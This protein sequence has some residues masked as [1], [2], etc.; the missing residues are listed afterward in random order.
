MYGPV[1]S[2]Y[3]FWWIFP[4]LMIILCFILMRSR[5]GSM[6]CGF[7]PRNFDNN[8]ARGS[9]SAIEI[10]DKRYASG[11]INTDEYEEKKRT[12]AEPTHSINE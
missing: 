1:L 10:L 12:L 9:D 8:Q 11:E 2:N 6:M 4:L 5:R 3:S 7:G